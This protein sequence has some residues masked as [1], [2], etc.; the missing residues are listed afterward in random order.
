MIILGYLDSNLLYNDT[1]F[2]NQSSSLLYSSGWQY[3][4]RIVFDIINYTFVMDDLLIDFQPTTHPSTTNPTTLTPSTEYTSIVIPS[5]LIPSTQIPSTEYTST[6]IPSTL[7]PSTTVPSTQ[8]PLTISPGCLYKLLNCERCGMNGMIV[9]QSLFN[10]TCVFISNDVWGYSYTPLFPNS[11]T[12]ISQTTTL[13]QTTI[14][15]G[16]HLEISGSLILNQSTIIIQGNLNQTSN[17]NIIITLNKKNIDQNSPYLNVSGCIN[18][19]GNIT[20]ILEERPQISSTNDILLFKYNCSQT[21]IILAQSQFKV[22]STYKKKECDKIG[23]NLLNQQNS[24]SVSLSTTLNSN[25]KPKLGLIIGLSVGV[26][27]FLLLVSAVVVLL[28][29]FHSKNESERIVS[30]YHTNM[31]ENKAH[32]EKTKWTNFYKSRVDNEM[33]K[34]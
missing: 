6:V 30:D 34:I 33:E 27:L 28:I 1:I 23:T 32:Q 16:G 17:S 22:E 12:I 26:P 15:I 10:I 24:L 13:N 5:T 7:I 14:L 21:T 20:L 29:R 4:N 18:L 25:C 8:I 19:G 9:D 31:K 3:I 2:L 11:T